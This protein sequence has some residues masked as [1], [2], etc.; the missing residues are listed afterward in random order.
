M[1]RK[2]DRKLGAALRSATDEMNAHVTGALEA[3]AGSV[4]DY[5]RSALDS[6]REQVAGLLAAHGEQIRAHVT[7]TAA[8]PAE[9]AAPAAEP[10][11]VPDP[12]AAEA[13]PARRSRM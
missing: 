5:V 13:P 8:E 7:R 10:P 6:H 2:S 9:P 3:H 1:S 4:R 11:G 12:V